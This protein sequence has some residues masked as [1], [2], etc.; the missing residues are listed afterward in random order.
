MFLIPFCIV[1]IFLIKNKLLNKKQK[2][3]E[4]SFFTFAFITSALLVVIAFLTGIFLLVQGIK[5]GDYGLIFGGEIFTSGSLAFLLAGLTIKGCFDNLKID[6]LGLYAGVVIAVIGLGFLLLK[7]RE[8]YSLIETVK[9]FGW[10]IVIPIMMTLVGIF[11]V[12]KCLKN[13]NS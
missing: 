8:F 5:E 2:K 4:E 6:V 13:R 11:Q 10:W 3:S 1:G 12:V 9:S 7:Y